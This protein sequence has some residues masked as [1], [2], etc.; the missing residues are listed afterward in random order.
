[1]LFV[2]AP[3]VS[4][5]STGLISFLPCHKAL[6]CG[7]VKR[8]LKFTK[9]VSTFYVLNADT[10]ASNTL[11]VHVCKAIYTHTGFSFTY[12]SYRHVL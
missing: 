9:Y 12:C 4:P 10:D 8:P 6:F 11:S 3:T 5:C 2:I 1:M 7:K